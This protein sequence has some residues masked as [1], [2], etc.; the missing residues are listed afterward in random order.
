MA[1]LT[2]RPV[3]ID[4]HVHFH[5]MYDPWAAIEG[6]AKNFSAG[7]TQLS[8]S[9]DV[10]G[11]LLRVRNAFEGPLEALHARLLREARQEWT[12]ELDPSKEWLGAV[13]TSDATVVYV[14]EGQQVRASNG[15]EVLALGGATRF[16]D[17]AP[18]A[19]MVERVL[20][21][22]AVTVIPW[23]FGKWLG[24][25]RREVARVLEPGIRAGGRLFLGDN[26]SRPGP[27]RDPSL[28]NRARELGIF[29]LPGSD[30][31]ALS[32]QERSVGRFGFVVHGFDASN[33]AASVHA[34]LLALD[35]Q[36]DV[37]GGRQGLL[38]S[39]HLQ[40]RLRTERAA[41]GPAAG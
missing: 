31:L 29:V 18:F 15:L 30:P 12:L 19:A 9:R 41:S 5:P 33:P 22:G 27:F 40:V 39:L 6:A 28:F 37:F 4:G 32:G 1:D 11:V 20:A 34:A 2:R 25:R 7:R 14:V 26:A 17:G 13:R 24:S 23:G 16:E 10:A 38:E 36:P 3:L 35:R 8:L 21:S